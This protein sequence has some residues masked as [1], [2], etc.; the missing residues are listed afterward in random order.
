MEKLKSGKIKIISHAG[1]STATGG[2][3]RPRF[4]F[5]RSASPA[6]AHTLPEASKAFP[7]EPLLKG[8][9]LSKTS[10]KM[11]AIEEWVDLEEKIVH[12]YG[13]RKAPSA[14]PTPSLNL[15][16]TVSYAASMPVLKRPSAGGSPFLRWGAVLV[17]AGWVLACLFAFFYAR[18]LPL[19]RE[20]SLRFS[21]ILEEKNRLEQS[22]MAVKK[23]SEEQSATIQK[24]DRRIQRMSGELQIFREKVSGS[25]LLE[26]KYRQELMRITTDYEIQLDALRGSLRSRDEIIASLRAQMQSI[27]KMIDQGSLSAVSG[28]A[29]RVT[30]PGAFAPS[31]FASQSGEEVSRG[32]VTVVNSRQG[33]FAVDIGSDRGARSGRPIQVFREGA[34]VGEGIL[35]R[36]YPTM[37]SVTMKNPRALYAVREGDLVTF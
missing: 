9:H 26:K 33:F 1:S 15:A 2:A 23:S 18:E 37:S 14:K 21:G 17:V 24:M 8:G 16:S 22:Y 32:R 11:A 13:N 6:S 28:I 4:S 20:A 25:D 12:A 30:Q 10:G 31:D 7:K 34:F 35:D 36:V 5:F 3:S 29:S 19:K 27:E